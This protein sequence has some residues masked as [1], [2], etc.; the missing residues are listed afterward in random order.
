MDKPE[1]HMHQLQIKSDLCGGMSSPYG[2]T[3]QP[4][5]SIPVGAFAA[6]FLVHYLASGSWKPVEQPGNGNRLFNWQAMIGPHSH[7]HMGLGPG[8][9]NPGKLDQRWIVWVAGGG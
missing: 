7:D 1:V 8:A 9:H 2:W 4:S 3:G 6:L 5:S